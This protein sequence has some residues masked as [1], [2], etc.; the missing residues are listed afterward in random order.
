MELRIKKGS[1]GEF[2]VKVR[3]GGVIQRDRRQAFCPEL[4]YN[5]AV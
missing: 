4:L 2:G 3:P 5:T 1:G